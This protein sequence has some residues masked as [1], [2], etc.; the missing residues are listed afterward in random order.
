[1]VM[2]VD[3]PPEAWHWDLCWQWKDKFASPPCSA[4]AQE[5]SLLSCLEKTSVPLQLTVGPKCKSQ[6]KHT[7]DTGKNCGQHHNTALLHMPNICILP[8]LLRCSPRMLI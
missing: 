1:M 5:D 2:F 3:C 7:A 6:N 4:P 8:A